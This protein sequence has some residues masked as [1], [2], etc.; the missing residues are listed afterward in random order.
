MAQKYGLGRAMGGAGLLALAFFLFWIWSAPAA[1]GGLGRADGQNGRI[2]Q[3][4]FAGPVDLSGMNAQEAREAIEAYVAERQS[5]KIWLEL[6]QGQKEQAT[7]SELGLYWANTQLVQEALD[8]GRKGNLLQRYKLR[9]DL[10]RSSKVLPLEWQVDVEY[11]NAFL[12]ERCAKYDKKAKNASLRRENGAFVIQEGEAGYVLDV[13]TS[14]DVVSDFL[15]GEWQGGEASIALDVQVEE[16]KGNKETLSQVKDLLGSFTT[17]YSTSGASRSANVANGCKLVNGRTVYPGEEFSVLEAI[18]PFT[19]ANGYHLAGSFLNGKVVDSLG[20][21]ICQVS[22]TLY[23]AVLL[24]ELEVS[25]RYNHSMIVSYVDPAADAAIA[26]SSDKDFCFVNNTDYPIYIEGYTENKRIT[27]NIYGKESRSK[28]RQVSYESQV[29]ETIAPGPDTIYADGGQ[30]IGYIVTDS[31]HTGYK[32]KLWKVVREN[33][34]E[35]E[36]ELVNN[37]SYKMTPRT[38]TVGVASADPNAHNEIMAAIGTGSIDHV[39]NVIGILTQTPAAV[40]QAPA[41]EAP[42]E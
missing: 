26:E 6:A 3:G 39:K 17:A 4:I 41:A 2:E 16:P 19:Q 8:L 20:G 27:I 36:R 37:S 15:T 22:T 38:A 32:A 10:A 35:K 13:E 31:A 18:T 23:N 40:T 14:I 1:A 24:S 7:A 21:G 42:V 5:E 25:E 30:G 28:D 29:L 9:A 12:L 34:V 11:V 33:G